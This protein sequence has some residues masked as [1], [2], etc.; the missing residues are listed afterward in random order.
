[1]HPLDS[2]MKLSEIESTIIHYCAREDLS[3][4]D[5]YDIWK[6]KIGFKIKKYYNHHKILAL[7][8]A[9]IATVCDIYVNN[10]FRA[11]YRQQEYPIVRAMA[12]LALMNVYKRKECKEHLLFSE[13]HIRWLLDNSCKGYSGKCWG[14]NF[15]WPVSKGLVYDENTPFATATPYVLEAL[16]QYALLTKDPVCID[17]IKSVFM[18]FKNDIKVLFE[19]V[20]SLATSY[21]PFKDRIVINALSYTLYSYGLLVQYYLNGEDRDFAEN[22]VR[23]LYR[24]IVDQQHENGSWMYSVGDNSFID[25]FHSCLVLKNIIKATAWIELNDAPNTVAKGYNY[26]KQAF[27]VEEDQLFKRFS[28]TNKMG[29]VKYDLYDNAEA[30]NLAIIMKDKKLVKVLLES[31]YR[32]FHKDNH[33]YSMIDVFGRKRNRDMMRWAIMPL[34]YSLSCIDQDLF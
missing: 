19:D 30:L 6:S 1:M 15:K 3:T 32:H 22:T 2:N 12:S 33:F 21:S 25:C 8:F 29:I 4:W 18:F 10:R 24:Y 26:I 5:P 7:P 14:L 20:D 28:L 16:H 27:W 34:V 9:A 11:F 13:K 23:K 17:A 31:I